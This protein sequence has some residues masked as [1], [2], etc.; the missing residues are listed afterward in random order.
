MKQIGYSCQVLRKII[1]Q[2]VNLVVVEH[3]LKHEDLGFGG[4]VETHKILA[5]DK[6]TFFQGKRDGRIS[7][8]D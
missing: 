7:H 2:I 3:S 4:Q 1:Q 5:Q 6:I 8:F